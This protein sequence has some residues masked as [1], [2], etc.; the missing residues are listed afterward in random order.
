VS[1]PLDRFAARVRAARNGRPAEPPPVEPEV[2][3]AE[4][5]ERRDGL[6]RDFAELQFDLGGLV[7]EMAARDHFRLDVVVRRAAR[8]QEVDA[9]L[10]EVE[11][12]LRL[13]EAS[14]AG[15]CPACGALYARGAAFCWQCGVTLLDRSVVRTEP[16]S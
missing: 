5:R 13:D 2:G 6:A 1:S 4:L 15:G 9:E 7:Y 16:P 3:S 8:L 12:L 14:A 10:A 11:R